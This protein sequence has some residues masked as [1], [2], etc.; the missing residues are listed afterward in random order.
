LFLKS[1][2]NSH[3]EVGLGNEIIRGVALGKT[4]GVGV[5]G[6]ATVTASGDGADVRVG[7]A[8]G[9]AAV[10]AGVGALKAKL[11]PRP[12]LAA[13]NA[14]NP[15]MI[16]TNTAPA[17]AHFHAEEGVPGTRNCVPGACCKTNGLI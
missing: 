16:T 13:L 7:T 4:R 8:V 17:P 9:G 6:A 10:G 15:K 14:S 12:E 1:S 2:V 3:I 5:D 11:I